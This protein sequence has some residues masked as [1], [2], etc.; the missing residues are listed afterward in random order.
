MNAPFEQIC[1]ELGLGSL[2]APPVPLHG[3]YMHRMYEM[4]TTQGRYAVKLLNP[5]VMQR[6]T[7]EENYRAA[8]AL[9]ALL[10]AHGLPVLPALVIGG[11]KRQCVAGQQLYVFD[12]YDGRPLRD[13]EITPAHCEKIGRAL[14]QIHACGQRTAPDRSEALRSIDWPALTAGLLR[15]PESSHEGFA[16]HDALHML[17]RM[18]RAARLAADALPDIETICHND[19]DSKNVLWQGDDFRIIDLECLGW[20]DPHQELMDLAISWAGSAPD[21]AC[22]QAFI[23]A[24]LAEGGN[25]PSDPEMIYDSRRN[26][27]DWLAA[28]AVRALAEDAQERRI[29]REQVL[30]TLEKLAS[31]QRNRE[32]ILTWFREVCGT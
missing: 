21:K 30:E 16:V 24:Y 19:M 22:F 11:K 27:L 12:Y 6:A 8:E 14:A 3:G 1:R 20:A 25:I 7:A 23:A 31:D 10:E 26:H 4:R 29:G 15:H 18:T 2:S 32:P 28:N 13:E 5:E 9:E 17:I